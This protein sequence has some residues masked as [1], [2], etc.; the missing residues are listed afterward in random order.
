MRIPSYTRILLC[1]SAVAV[2]SCGGKKPKPTPI[3]PFAIPEAGEAAIS[4]F[5]EGKI[6]FF[7]LAE[8]ARNDIVNLIKLSDSR[9]DGTFTAMEDGVLSEE[10]NKEL[11]E[12]QNQEI[13]TYQ[14][15]ITTLDSFLQFLPEGGEV[16]Q[17]LTKGRESLVAKYESYFRS[18]DAGLTDQSLDP[19][20]KTAIE[21]NAR[22]LINELQFIESFLP[23][24]FDSLLVGPTFVIEADSVDLFF[25][26]VRDIE[27]MTKELEELRMTVEQFRRAKGEMETFL[28]RE[29]LLKDQLEENQVEIQKLYAELDTTR[30]D[31][32]EEFDLLDKRI[33]SETETLSRQIRQ[34]D[35]DIRTDISELAIDIAD[36][37]S[38]QK[39]ESD[40]LFFSVGTNLEFMREEI[41]SIKG[42]VRYYDIAEKG[43]PIIDEEVLNILKLP[44]L[45]H[46][47]TLKNGTIVIGLILAENM[48]IIIMQT[49]I[50]KL[51]IEKD[52]IAKYNEKEF[53][54]PKV[55]F[56]GDYKV[57][58]YADREEFI[59][60][61]KNVGLK[62]ADFVK[63]SF[64]LWGATTDPVGV[65]SALV[66]GN[67]VKFAT[68]V[69]SDASI[70]PEMTARYRVVVEKQPG[71]K[72]AYRTNTVKWREYK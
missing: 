43:L 26:V 12:I 35:E 52:F 10:E 1:F 49:T 23:L 9:V 37:I 64:F 32:R 24:P 4:A 11:V 65:G 29:K 59:G 47:L 44:T 42:L 22:S 57:Q 34:M 46:K 30:A 28:N 50:G 70:E 33:L 27:E 3:T 8:R 39:S 15:L 53:P 67:V 31:Q 19:L 18:F 71:I 62:R 17:N 54:G 6:D 16:D 25:E 72:V 60:W 69:I 66:D 7:P 48:D 41:D 58:E 55:V 14:D 45:R 36:S 13:A 20:E 56:E 61:V 40:S 5:P 2:F 38:S 68:G 51:V 63:I 21:S